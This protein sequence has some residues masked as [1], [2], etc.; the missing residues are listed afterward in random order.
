[1]EI[2]GAFEQSVEQYRRHFAS[3]LRIDGLIGGKG[4]MRLQQICRHWVSLDWSLLPLDNVITGLGD[5]FILDFNT[6]QEFWV[7]K[8]LILIHGLGR[9]M[10][11]FE[12][13]NPDNP[14]LFV[15]RVINIFEP[16]RRSERPSRPASAI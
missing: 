6:R 4:F 11:C 15:L 16:M 12:L 13:E 9:V 10:T 2:P 7:I 1:V 3:Q 14:H 5:G 8:I